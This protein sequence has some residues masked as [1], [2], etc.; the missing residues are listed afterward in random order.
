MN[1]TNNDNEIKEAFAE[2]KSAFAK[3]VLKFNCEQPDL[4]SDEMVELRKLHTV[5]KFNTIS[6]D[7]DF[8]NDIQDIH[9]NICNNSNTNKKKT[10]IKIKK[11]Q[12][13]KK[14]KKK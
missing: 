3:V 11:K 10:K 4:K 5:W 2:T 9:T 12:K 1:Y 13:K 8:I 7:G 6:Y 14:T